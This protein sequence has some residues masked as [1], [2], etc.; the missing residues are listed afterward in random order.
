MAVPSTDTLGE[1]TK[2]GNLETEFTPWIG[3]NGGFYVFAHPG[4]LEVE[5]SGVSLD[6]NVE[7]LRAILAS[8]D[9]RVVD[10]ANVTPAD[11]WEEGRKDPDLATLSTE[12]DQEGV[13]I[14]N[15]TALANAGALNMGWSVRTNCDRYVF[16][17]AG[18]F[19]SMSSIFLR[20]HHQSGSIWF[21]PIDEEMT[22]DVVEVPDS[23]SDIPVRDSTGEVVTTLDV[24]DGE[25]STTVPAD[26]GGRANAPWEL[27]LSTA[28]G[29]IDIDGVTRWPNGE[30]PYP[31]LR[32]WAT[33]P[34]QWFPVE[35]NRWLLRPYRRHLYGTPG[36]SGNQSYTIINNAPE[37]RT[38]DLTLEHTAG[39][40]NVA[41]SDRSIEVPA[42]DKG[43]VTLEYTLPDSGGEART[44]RLVIGPQDGT[45]YTTYASL[46]A[47]TKRK[48]AKPLSTPLRLRPYRHENAQ[49]G[50]WSDYPTTWEKYVDLNNRPSVRVP[51]GIKTLRDGEWQLSDFSETVESTTKRFEGTSFESNRQWTKIAY[52]AD[53]DMYFT[54]R[55]DDRWALL[56][57][58]DGGRNFTAYE[59]RSDEETIDTFVDMGIEHFTGH[60][61]PS[62]PPAI[63][64]EIKKGGPTEEKP[65]ATVSDLELIPV[66]KRDGKLDVS[67]PVLLSENSLGI[68]SHS[69]LPGVAASSDSR[70]HVV[71]GEATDPDGDA[72]GVPTYV[73]SYDLERQELL[74]NPA[75]VGYGKPTNDAHNR[76]AITMDSEGYLHV[77]TG[78]H[79]DT[80]NYARSKMPDTAHD[81]WTDAVPVGDGLDGTYIG[82]VCDSNDTL[83]LVY[84]LWQNGE[85][86]FPNAYHGKLVYQRKPK[87]ESWESPRNL[88][89]S[90]F[91]DY[92]VFYHRLTIDRQDRLM[93]SYDYWSTFRF[94]RQDYPEQQGH[95]R[96]TMFSD[97]G[98][99]SWE[100]LQND[101]LRP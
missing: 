59:L 35:L 84:R 90:A 20:D 22:V 17:S 60:N 101:D 72:P 16:D 1:R 34:E 71:W 81:G 15:V 38:F 3:K 76:P 44:T 100:L 23:V 33:G 30:G 46:S 78:T 32:L 47:S 39:S 68:G 97:D 25:A 9:R 12:V 83:H 31:G 95:H 70:I 52:D 40:W 61:V 75:L 57:S 77:L 91:P 54:G 53:N 66:D 62:G 86:P 8:P 82:L 49:F 94:Y 50:Y 4:E 93:L 51:E 26:D 96:K 80:F 63:I 21:Q 67:D 10:S 56:H 5:I 13:Y 43:E 29:K 19:G 6:D 48:T 28:R 92:S 14:V 2:P 98:G 99:D 24:E 87:G 55:A 74:G 36:E 89:V 79:G 69:G 42:Y 65:W 11:S 45:E 41:L 18:H 64:R 7:N 73:V 27:E 58:R 85:E 88:V 37:P